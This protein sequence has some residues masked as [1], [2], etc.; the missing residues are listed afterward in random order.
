MKKDSVSL[1]GGGD[2]SKSSVA[3]EW[4]RGERER[5]QDDCLLDYRVDCFIL[6]WCS[7]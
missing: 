1:G 5:A 6:E 4:G 7:S 2:C 3:R